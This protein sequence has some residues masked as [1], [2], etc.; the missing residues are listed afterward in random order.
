MKKLLILIIL[1]ISSV[2]SAQN[3]F[4]VYGMEGNLIFRTR[5]SHSM[6]KKMNTEHW[7]LDYYDRETNDTNINVSGQINIDEPFIDFLDSNYSIEYLDS[8]YLSRPSY[9]FKPNGVWIEFSRYSY[10]STLELDKKYEV[11]D[12]LLNGF[13]YRYDGNKLSG[14]TEYKN[15]YPTGIEYYIFQNSME[16][17]H[18]DDSLKRSDFNI[19]ID[20]DKR[21]VQINDL[22]EG[23]KIRS[24]KLNK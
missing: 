17:N 13:F 4:E 18:F 5:D 3:I 24:T 20:F 16:L 19:I 8:L 22:R 9:D 12:S 15:G 21:K 2:S 10:D 1:F 7:E 23:Q 6:M 11:R 14:I